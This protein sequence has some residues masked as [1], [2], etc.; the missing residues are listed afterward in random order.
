[1][2][3]IRYMGGNNISKWT[4]RLAIDHFMW[5]I[6][7]HIG[8]ILECPLQCCKCSDMHA[9]ILYC[10]HEHQGISGFICPL[11]KATH[12]HTCWHTHTILLL[13]VTHCQSTMGFKLKQE[14]T[15]M[16]YYSHCG[17]II[18]SASAM[19]L[20]QQA[21]LWYHKGFTQGQS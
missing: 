4:N 16:N 8:L 19:Q 13:L 11:H 12:T 18:P 10:S 17:H 1:M 9:G 21:L 7:Y 3:K 2:A 15:S 5:T 14:C 20:Q 6:K